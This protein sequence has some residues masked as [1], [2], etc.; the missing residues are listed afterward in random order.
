[1]TARELGNLK[2][3][4]FQLFIDNGGMA[5]KEFTTHIAD[6]HTLLDQIHDR[7]LS[8]SASKTELFMTEAV[9]AGATVGPDGIKPD[10]TKLTAIVDWQQ[11]TNLSS[12]E[13]FLG[14]TVRG[15]NKYFIYYHLYCG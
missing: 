12:L 2:D 4:L 14:L 13:S 8:L 3:K 11:P 7:K 6:L 10:L 5:G 9:F 1:M 15:P